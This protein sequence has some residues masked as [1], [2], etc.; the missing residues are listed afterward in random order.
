MEERVQNFIRENKREFDF[1]EPPAGLWE[2]IEKG[3]DTKQTTTPKASRVV[4]LSFLLQL[5]ASLAVIVAAGLF[6]WQYQYKQATD[7]ANID[8]GL[9]KQQVHY[10]S[11]IEI[12]RSELKRIEKEEPQL[13]QEFS[14]EIRKM[15]ESYQRLKRDLP[16]SPNQEE[17]VKAMIRNLQIQA[18]VLNQQL[19]VI[20]QINDSKK[21]QNDETQSI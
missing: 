7:L 16:G 15:D 2:K 14:S 13:Y 10:A 9:A 6:L 11:V 3:L 18:E 20:K 21:Q 1:A 5:A 19:N 4:K 17:T 12:K 8:P